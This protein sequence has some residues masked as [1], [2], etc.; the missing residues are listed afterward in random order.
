MRLVALIIIFCIILIAVNIN[1]T[2]VQEE[3][4]LCGIVT[5]DRDVD[6]A[7]QLYQAVKRECDDV[8]IVCRE[9]DTRTL[10][11][12]SSRAI[13]RTVPH[14]KIKRRH[15]MDMIAV[16]RKI[17]IDYARDEGYDAVWFVDADVIPTRG[18]LRE[19]LSVRADL[20]IAPYR[21]KWL[22]GTTQIGTYSN[23]VPVLHEITIWD[24][25]LHSRECVIGGFGCT[26]IRRTAF[27]CAIE[28]RKI[29]D[30]SGFEVHG[31]DIGFF[32]NC[33]ESGLKCRYLT[34]NIQPHL[35]D[36]KVKPLKIKITDLA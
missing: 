19:L 22:G 31:E 24:K 7:E 28:D 14:Y 4:V 17:I 10:K 2:A 3:R 8:M 18:V 15:N 9:T 32:L 5:I 34:R 27:D 1:T 13:T 25:L 11:F 35:Y 6:V 36:R 20:C 26:V 23:G 30:G 12:W 29:I 33:A 21:V 16:K